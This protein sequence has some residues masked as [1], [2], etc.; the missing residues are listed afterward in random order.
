MNRLIGNPDCC[1]RFRRGWASTVALAAQTRM[2]LLL[3]QPLIF[4][5]ATNRS[6]V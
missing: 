2:L 5:Q 6:A 1:R 4:Q 3:S